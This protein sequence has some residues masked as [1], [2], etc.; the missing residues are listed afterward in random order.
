MKSLTL[1]SNK[2]AVSINTMR[3]VIRLETISQRDNNKIHSFSCLSASLNSQSL[4]NTN[5]LI[6][7]VKNC[8]LNVHSWGEKNISVHKMQLKGTNDLNWELPP[9]AQSACSY[10]CHDNVI[11]NIWS[12]DHA[13]ML[14]RC[15]L[16]VFTPIVLRELLDLRMGIM[17]VRLD[18]SPTVW[19]T[20]V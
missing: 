13:R 2:T 7:Y 11:F 16:D 6:S 3:K 18:Q 4:I 12:S 8:A 19:T 5:H 14:M 1:Y 10:N 20:V 15:G 17:P 9:K